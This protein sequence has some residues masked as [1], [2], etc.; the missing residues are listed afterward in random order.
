M[1]SR[2][3][4]LT[5]HR[6][7][8]GFRGVGVTAWIKQCVITGYKPAWDDVVAAQRAIGF[9]CGHGSLRSHISLTPELYALSIESAK[10]WEPN[11]TYSPAKLWSIAAIHRGILSGFIG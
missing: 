2:K 3:I 11:S 7:S 4:Y 1:E 5:Y 8:I 6:P 10:A 9:D